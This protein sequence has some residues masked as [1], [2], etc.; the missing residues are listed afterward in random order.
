MYSILRTWGWNKIQKDKIRYDIVPIF[1]IS[2]IN[3]FFVDAVTMD[4]CNIP[5]KKNCKIVRKSSVKEFNQSYSL[6]RFSSRE[7]GC[8]RFIVEKKLLLS[9]D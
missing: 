4:N 6:P 1:Y 3:L 5:F 2:T 8:N 9:I 7:D